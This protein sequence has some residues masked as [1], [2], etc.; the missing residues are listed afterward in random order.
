MMKALQAPHHCHRFIEKEVKTDTT[1]H[2]Q[3]PIHSKYS[4]IWANASDRYLCECSSE[5]PDVGH[6]IYAEP[7]Q[8]QTAGRNNIQHQQSLLDGINHQL[9]RNEEVPMKKSLKGA[10]TTGIAGILLAGGLASPASAVEGNFFASAPGPGLCHR[11]DIEFY[12]PNSKQAPRKEHITA[13]GSQN[14]S[15]YFKSA[16]TN[17]RITANY[18]YRSPGAR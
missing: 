8:R 3:K 4:L 15:R 2:S 11:F 9:Q 7:N 12:T 14:Q 10:V 18:N 5:R 1:E 17:W 16:H 6:I 13:C